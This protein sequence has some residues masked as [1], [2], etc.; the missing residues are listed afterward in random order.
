MVLATER[1]RRGLT[2]REAAEMAGCSHSHL[3]QVERHAATPSMALT[4]ALLRLYGDQPIIGYLHEED[5]LRRG[6]EEGGAEPGRDA[7]VAGK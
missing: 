4:V 3:S 6:Q 1:R 7:P 5:S 2:L